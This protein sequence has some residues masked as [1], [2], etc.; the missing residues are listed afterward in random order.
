MVQRYLAGIIEMDRKITDFNIRLRTIKIWELI[1]WIVLAAIITGIIMEIFPAVY[2]NDDLLFMVLLFFVLL[3][4]AWALKGTTGL[5]KNFNDLFEKTTRNEI[6][7]VFAINIIFAFLFTCLVGW[8]DLLM[9][10]ADPYW[11]SGLDIDSVDISAGA[12]LLSAI[13]SIIFAPLLEELTFRGV[14]FSRLKI[15]IGIVPAMIITSFLFG[16]GHDFGGITSAFLFGM[17][18]CILYLKTDNILV[19]ISV[20]FINN[21]VATIL[22]LT[23][24]DLFL[25]QLPWLIPATA[26]TLISAVLLVKYIVEQ[27][28]ALKKIYG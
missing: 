4:F 6:L 9:G 17:C 27:T 20:H 14:L 21:V 13:A 18:M 3:F 2:D 7:Y 15:R 12:F 8:L 11:V 26:I 10:I 22:E 19:P 1:I 28:G 25:T 16:I 5:Q 23:S 24:I